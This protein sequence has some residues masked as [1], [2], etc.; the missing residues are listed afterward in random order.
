[1]CLDEIERLQRNFIWGDTDDVKKYF[2]MSWDMMLG[3]N[4]WEVLGLRKLDVVNQAWTELYSG[5]NDFWCEVLRITTIILTTDKY[6]CHDLSSGILPSL[7]ILV[8]GKVL[9]N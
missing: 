6:D 1:V 7:C 8:G 4:V 5:A 3:L 9:S 2:A